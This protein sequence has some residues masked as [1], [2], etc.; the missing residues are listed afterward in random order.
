VDRLFIQNEEFAVEAYVVLRVKCGAR[1]GL[2]VRD[3]RD[4]LCKRKLAVL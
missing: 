4:Q 3:V 2:K 1:D